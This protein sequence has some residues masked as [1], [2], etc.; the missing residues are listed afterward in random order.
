MRLARRPALPL[1][2]WGAVVVLLSG[3]AMLIAATLAGPFVAMGV[4]AA[5]VA[6]AATVFAPALVV[7][8]APIA[9]A[10]L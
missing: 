4:L 5:T 3:A 8:T 2:V 9:S 10:L 1:A 6:L 7:V